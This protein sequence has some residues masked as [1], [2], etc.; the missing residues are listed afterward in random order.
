MLPNSAVSFFDYSLSKLV[1]CVL[2][3]PTVAASKL[4]AALG[5]L[6]IGCYSESCTHCRL[7]SCS[8]LAI[9]PAIAKEASCNI[10]SPNDGPTK[11]QTCCWLCVT[12]QSWLCRGRLRGFTAPSTHSCIDSANNSSAVTGSTGCTDMM[13]GSLCP[14]SEGTLQ[15]VSRSCLNVKVAKRCAY[16]A[17]AV[18][19]RQKKGIGR[20]HIKED[21][22]G[23][24]N[25][26]ERHGAIRRFL[27]LLLVYFF[28]RQCAHEDRDEQD[29]T[30]THEMKET[31]LV[32]DVKYHQV[33]S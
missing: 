30:K 17:V 8:S 28:W 24:H 31:F 15:T 11:V 16:R 22:K 7:V 26:A 19:G 12:W 33:T 32:T 29:T 20:H 10:E 6:C 23:T 2:H 9:G 14:F 3:V 25:K 13:E 18:H 21:R 27:F 5:C 4:H 1:V